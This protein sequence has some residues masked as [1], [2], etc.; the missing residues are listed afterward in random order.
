MI[1]IAWETCSDNG[2]P[3]LTCVPLL[4]GVLI[5]WALIFAGV[6]AFF[7]LLYGGLRF[8]LSGGD[9]TAVDGARKTITY[10]IIG[11]I[12]VLT[13]FFIVNFIAGATNV[14]C[15]KTFGFSN[16]Q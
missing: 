6:I 1:R 10:A 12:V 7:F 3:K 4:F 16:C 15:I 14:E 13:S 2:I 8:I 11:L 9:K 5:H